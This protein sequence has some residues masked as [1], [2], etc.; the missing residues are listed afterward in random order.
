MTR[1]TLSVPTTEEVLA[2]CVGCDVATDGGEACPKESKLPNG[3][4]SRSY[5]REH[6]ETL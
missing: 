5:E 6:Q 4:R 2:R 1:Y 3:E